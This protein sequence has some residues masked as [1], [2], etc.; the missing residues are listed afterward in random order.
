MSGP[1]KERIAAVLDTRRQGS[2]YLLTPRLVLTAAHVVVGSDSI[3]VIVPGGRGRIPCRTV[4]EGTH[5][6]CDVALL[7]AADD[8]VAPETAADWPPVRWGQTSDLRPRPDCQA[9]GFPV[10][11]RAASGQLDSEQLIG[12]LKPGSSI[13]R[14]RYVVD[15][16]HTPPA[17]QQ[18]GGSPWAGMSGAALF[19]G[20]LLV[21]VVTI[22]P[23]GWQHGRLTAVPATAIHIV[24]GFYDAY[25]E[26]FGELPTLEGEARKRAPR[27][28]FE[29]D[30]RSYVEQNYGELR[31]FGLDFSR[32]DHAQWPLDT[33]YLSLEL[34]HQ[35]SQDRADLLEAAPRHE[36]SSGRQRVE[37]ALSGR[38]RV[39]LRGL[40]G[41]GKT[42]LIQWLAI[43]AARDAFS[44]RLGH[45]D[46]CVPFVLPLRTLI[47]HG[48]LP[49]PGEFLAATGTPLSQPPGWAERMMRDG[50]ALLLIDGVDEIPE[51]DRERTQ[52]WLTALLA[53]YPD[54]T[55]VVTTRPAAVSEGWLAR[56]DFTELN[57]LPMNRQDVEAF[58]GRWHL[59]AFGEGA[60]AGTEPER[61]R[62]AER[63]LDTLRRK[64][65]LARLA[66]NPLMCAMICALHRDRRTYLPESRMELYGAALTMLLVRRD[67]E[68]DVGAPEG[69][70]IPEDA[71][72]QLLQEFAWWLIRNGQTEAEQDRVVRLIERLLPAM[73][74]VA[75]PERARDVFRYLL[76]R[77][78]LLREPT[79]QT[80]DFVH[81]TFQDYL[82]AKAAV[83][84]Q[85]LPQVA[86][87][88]ADPQWE[89]VVRMA[90]GHGRPEERATLISGLLERGD[91]TRDDEIRTRLHLLAAASLEHATMLAPTVRREAEERAAGLIPPRDFEAAEKLAGAGPVVLD[92]LPGPDQLDDGE[93]AATVET[94][95]RIGGEHAFHI[96]RQFRDHPDALVRES[97]VGAWSSFD[98]H[99]FVDELLSVM[100]LTD[101]HLTV[102]TDSQLNALDRVGRVR[103]LEIN[104]SFSKKLMLPGLLA[105]G[106]TELRLVSNDS[107]RGLDFLDTCAPRL[108]SLG[109]LDCGSL[110]DY[111]GISDTNIEHLQLEMMP[112]GPDMSPLAELRSLTSISINSRRP[113]GALADLPLPS[114]M[115]SLSLGP[116]TLSASSLDGIDRWPGLRKLHLSADADS[117]F[118][119]D[120]LRK[121]VA[122]PE[123]NELEMDLT[124]L[125]HLAELHLPRLPQIQSLLLR[126]ETGSRTGFSE[127]LDVFP[128]LRVLVVQLDHP[129]SSTLEADVSALQDVLASSVTVTTA[130]KVRL[131]GEETLPRGSQV[132]IH[133]GRAPRAPLTGMARFRLRRSR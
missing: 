5:E 52:Q 107:F 85:D 58:V 123:L 83:E 32:G 23:D 21:G 2:G 104:G 133:G 114:G 130:G 43:T 12:T 65:D 111:S 115:L 118:A 73:P 16:V 82:G 53:A 45:L 47:R 86:E 102:G 4:W 87:H 90:V 78:G 79:P 124:Q 99:R 37:A 11:Q 105:T 3:H 64:R 61:D 18:D 67:K 63:L 70:D 120:E 129:S 15:L 95:A 113:W 54:C 74:G 46:D 20:E 80:V 31:I 50:R 40:A 49:S 8:L 122:L 17:P 69:F 28:G 36:V 33:A 117:P 22:D 19:D 10:V 96:L 110:K 119:P 51:R 92:L 1:R 7:L 132:K 84:A 121:L 62:Y 44:Y 98:D 109:L 60:E 30:Y 77:S 48:E 42:T 71:Q 35:S 66:A 6:N 125:S 34:S 108:R 24:A 72:R 29:S 81:R 128:N 94:A 13:V 88:A 26:H 131:T 116:S 112:V 93:A 68:R 101:A 9:V 14:G 56:R 38:R 100:D 57:L 126:A 75:P 55:C 106:P 25:L 91:D 59:A 76:R 27:T 41:S 97:L 89:D 39:L 103:T 127:L